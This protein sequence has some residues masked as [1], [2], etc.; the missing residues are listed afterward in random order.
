MFKKNHLCICVYNFLYLHSHIL[1]VMTVYK[2]LI[3][4][5]DRSHSSEKI[6]K[7]GI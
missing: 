7:N 3:P 4:G 5:V 6:Q 2:K 1:F